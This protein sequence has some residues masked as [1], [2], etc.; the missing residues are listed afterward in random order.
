[1][2][3]SYKKIPLVISPM[4]EMSPVESDTDPKPSIFSQETIDSVTELGSVL[5]KIHNRLLSEGYCIMA[6]R[7]INP[8]GEVEY[9]KPSKHR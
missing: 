4:Y 2:T 6:N 8:Q 9:E 5:Q 1:M 7:V 3:R